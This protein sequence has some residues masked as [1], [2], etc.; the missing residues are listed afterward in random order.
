METRRYQKDK[1]G[2]SP[3]IPV[4]FTTGRHKTGTS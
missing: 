4:I 2:N 3:Q 1:R